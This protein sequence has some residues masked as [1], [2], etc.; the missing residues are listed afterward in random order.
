MNNFCWH[1]TR[2]KNAQVHVSFSSP[3][4][5]RRSDVGSQTKVRKIGEDKL[6]NCAEVGET[7]VRADGD[8]KDLAAKPSTCCSLSQWS[9]WQTGKWRGFEGH[10]EAL[11]S[12]TICGPLHRA[13]V[14]FLTPW[15]RR[16]RVA[17]ILGERR[18]FPAAEISLPGNAQ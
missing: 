14:P 1:K 5:V 16:P 8:R 13:E 12:L 18:D 2:R 10:S 3:Q 17:V 9:E 15:G 6:Q 4:D 11:R 7:E